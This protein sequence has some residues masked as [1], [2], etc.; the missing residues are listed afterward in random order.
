MRTVGA[1]VGLT[2]SSIS[3]I[4]RGVY[5]PRR[6]TFLRLTDFLREKGYEVEGA[7]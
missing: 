4:E 1:A 5:K 2:Q 7:A 3:Y 6:T